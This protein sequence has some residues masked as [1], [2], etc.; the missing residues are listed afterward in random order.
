MLPFSK[1]FIWVT[2][3]CLSTPVLGHRFFERAAS[4]PV[5]LN[6][7]VALE[8]V[9]EIVTVTPDLSTLVYSDGKTKKVGFVSISDPENPQPYGTVAVAGEP[10]SVVAV[11]SYVLC[12]VNTSPNFINPSGAL[13]VID[14]TRRTIVRTI[15]LNGQPDSIS[16]SPDGK[17]VL[18]AIENE[19]DED[20]GDGRPP[21]LPAGF[22]WVV[23][24]DGMPS[25]WTL[26]RVDLTGLPGMKFPTDPEPE[27]VAINAN[28]EGVVTLQENNHLAIVNLE[29]ASVTASFTAGS[30]NLTDIDTKEEGVISQNS[31]LTNVPREP[32]AVTWIGTDFFATADEGDL[33][34]GS[35]GFT[36]FKSDG[37]V[38]YTSGNSIETAVT[39]I[40]HYPEERSQNKGNEPE[41][42][43][44]SKFGKDHL[45]L[46]LQSVQALRKPV[47]TLIQ[48]LPAGLAPEGLLAIPSRGLLVVANE[49]DE[50]SSKFR[51]SISIYTRTAR[52]RVRSGYPTIVSRN[53][54]GSSLPIPWGAL[55][56][57]AA[58]PKRRKFSYTVTDSF[59]KESRIL[60]LDIRRK[61]AEITKEIMIKTAEGATVNLDCEGITV[62]EDGGFWIASEGNADG[63]RLNEIIRVHE[64]GVI[65]TRVQLPAEVRAL[66]IRFGFEGISSVGKGS[67]ELVYVAFQREWTSDPAGMVRIG[68]YSVSSNEWR[69]FYYPLDAPLSP[70]GGWVGLS[71][72]VS[73]KCRGD[74]YGSEGEVFAVLE[75]DNQAGPDARIKRVYKINIKGV[76]P[77]TQA[78]GT[79][80]FPVL[81]KTLIKDLVP[82]LMKPGG[83]VIEKVEGL[84]QTRDKHLYIVT[85][86]D[87]VDDSNGETQLLNI[88]R[89]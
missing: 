47:P 70:N 24:L 32:D 86:N 44:Y 3:L 17:Y 53:K 36:I 37:S 31:S 57:L 21:Q 15:Q 69:F 79:A 65:A 77:K 76:T 23:K 5:F 75:R 59:Y 66:R 27:F 10:T 72:I 43:L 56:A 8:T 58:D 40:G 29:T 4:F 1:A 84:M 62:R 34:G 48:I 25:S 82:D 20:L 14:I 67:A 78:D 49:D 81:E 71:E 38:F 73:V 9:A 46:S 41:G 16:S 51:S 19:R 30:V 33:D 35:R 26:T 12:A 87:G 13:Q 68:R 61:P 74:H 39:R 11:G 6:T 83:F 50:R 89:C 52:S 64:N 2:F 60:V 55:S 45:L 88:G 54:A 7:D 85:D 28:N 80:S 42:I 22:L 18:V 63:T